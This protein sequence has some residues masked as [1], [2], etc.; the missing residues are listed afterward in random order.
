MDGNIM[1]TFMYVLVALIITLI[2]LGIVLIIFLRVILSALSKFAEELA[3]R[4][5][6][7][8]E[9]DAETASTE[10]APAPAPEPIK[11]AEKVVVTTPV[12]IREESY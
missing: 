12:I 6:Q 5:I 9:S 4:T 2:F 11:D 1:L 8:P 10:P 7:S 3:D